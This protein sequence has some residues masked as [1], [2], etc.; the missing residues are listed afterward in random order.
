MSESW[1]VITG[2]SGGIGTALA[3]AFQSGST[4][5]VGIDTNAPHHSHCS[6][7]IQMDLAKAG[8]EERAA[9]KLCDTIKNTIGDGHLTTLINNA[10]AQHVGPADQLG[11]EKW[12]TS[13]DVN[14]SAPFA[15]ARGLYDLL[16]TS[17]GCIINIGSVHANASKPGFAAYATSKA[18]LH[19]LTRALAL[20]FGGHVRVVTLAPAAVDTDMLR[21]GFVK[22]P[23]AI[24]NL[25]NAHPVRRIA[26]PNEVADAALYLASNSA[27]FLTGSVL[28]MD[29]GVLA[30]LHDPE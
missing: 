5:V 24:E 4:K 13:L 29:G 15:L 27:G 12:Q 30:R 19:G 1:V 11:W 7:F 18:A 2:V 17:R 20:D 14:V 25:A 8:R 3:A 21:A 6:S 23:S 9:W 16:K 28:Y 10:A 26:M 22:N